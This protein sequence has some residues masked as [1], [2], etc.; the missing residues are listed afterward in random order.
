MNNRI[1]RE[2]VVISL[3][4]LKIGSDLARNSLFEQL[5]Y[6][7]K[8]RR[9]FNLLGLLE[10]EEHLKVNSLVE[11][12]KYTR[13]TILK[14]LQELKVYFKSSILWI[15]DENNYHFFLQDPYKY[16]QKKQAL[17]A[18]EPLFNFFDYLARG[19]QFT[20]SQWAQELGVSNANF[21]RM[22][23]QLQSLFVKQYKVKLD[24][25]SNLLTGKE[26]NIR[27]LLYDFYFS[28]PVYPEVLVE[29]INQMRQSKLRVKT[30]EWMIDEQIMN[31]WGVIAQ[32]RIIQ[33]HELTKRGDTILLQESL[34]QALDW[35]EKIAF[36]DHEKAALFLL[37]LKEEQFLKPQIQLSFIQAFPLTSISH[38]Y[39]LQDAGLPY[40]FLVTYLSLMHVFFQVDSLDLEESEKIDVLGGELFFFEIQREVLHQKEYYRKAL[41]VNYS[42]TGSTVLKRWIKEEVEAELFRTGRLMVNTPE[43][44]ER[45][46]LQHL[47]VSNCPM[48]SQKKEGIVLPQIP[49]K[50]EIKQ[51]ITRCLV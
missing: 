35:Q 47:E 1:G 5:I 42:L 34:A 48:I 31:Q 38:C 6:K 2:V 13:R 51:A 41:C 26:T 37:S 10:Q 40:Q 4:V 30:R 25:K 18:E 43:L 44:V 49:S 50:E 36:P 45:V 17:L 9:W 29:K 28:L 14:D 33:G 8:I 46:F 15:S 12:T 39:I 20:N 27:R 32:L 3:P 21:G 19:K 24:S 7:R 11:K 23:H 16:E 22:K